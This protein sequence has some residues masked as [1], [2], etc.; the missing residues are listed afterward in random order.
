[1]GEGGPSILQPTWNDHPAGR[2]I[3]QAS[4]LFA[5][6]GNGESPRLVGGYANA[7]HLLG[8]HRLPDRGKLESDADARLPGQEA[9]WGAAILAVQHI[10]IHRHPDIDHTEHQDEDLHTDR[11]RGSVH[12][13]GHPLPPPILTQD[14]IKG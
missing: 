3:Q 14:A 9:Y 13:R 5:F 4:Q 12:E 11:G 8:C 10:S 2:D 1:M 6:G 7:L